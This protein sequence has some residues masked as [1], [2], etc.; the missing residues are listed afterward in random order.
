M[1]VK[2]FISGQGGDEETRDKENLILA[3]LAELSVTFVK[4]DLSDPEQL[5]GRQL[6]FM[7]KKAKVREGEEAAQPPQIFNKT[8]RGDFLDFVSADDDGCLE[9][10]L[11]VK[12]TSWQLQKPKKPP[13]KESTPPAKEP[14][15]PPKE[16]TPPPKDS[17]PPPTPSP[18]E[19]TPPRD[20]TPPPREPTP[21]PKEPTPPPKEPTP[22]PKEPTPPP[23]E[24]TPPPKEPTPPPKEPTP[25][26][27]KLTPPPK[28]ATRATTPP[29]KVG[30][31]NFCGFTAVQDEM[32]SHL[33]GKH[34]I[35]VR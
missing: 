19:P 30:S 21:P 6:E 28:K 25:P 22:P 11:G 35:F 14:S 7:Q 23:K 33:A 1:G 3:R 18:K 9:E 5:D 10:F 27:R 16:P 4:V 31:C 13:P 32:I 24:P 34:K 29:L 12:I 17:T 8:Y 2:V 26:P 20:P 15:P